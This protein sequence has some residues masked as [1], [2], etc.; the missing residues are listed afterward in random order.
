MELDKDK[1]L[2]ERTAEYEKDPVTTLQDVI[3]KTNEILYM[4][5]QNQS[6]PSH[7]IKGIIKSAYENNINFLSAIGYL[8]KDN[9]NG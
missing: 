3:L 6:D 8:E 5:L 2:S 9:P 1:W 4:S 7:C